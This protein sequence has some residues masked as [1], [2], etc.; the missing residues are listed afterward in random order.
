MGFDLNFTKKE[1]DQGYTLE[2][3]QETQL[4]TNEDDN[5][6]KSLENYNN[7]KIEFEKNNFKVLNP[8]MF[9]TIGENDDIILRS[10]KEFKDVYEN[11]NYFKWSDYYKKMVQSSFIDDWLKDADMRTY[12]KLDFLP[13]QEVPEMFIIHLQDLKQKKKNFLILILKTLY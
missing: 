7:I 11:L 2:Q 3:L 1:M 9:V 12:Y 13:R 6:T 5:I 10:K 8:I 4:K